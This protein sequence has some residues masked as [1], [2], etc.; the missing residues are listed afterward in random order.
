MQMRHVSSVLAAFAVHVA[1]A[2]GQMM[3][4]FINAL[5]RRSEK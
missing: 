1:V 4:G 3:P 2:A 5:K